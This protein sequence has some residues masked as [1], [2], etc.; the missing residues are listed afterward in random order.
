[1]KH[2]SIHIFIL[3]AAVLVAAPQ[4]SQ[5]IAALKT[6]LGQRVKAEIY[7][8]FLN[9][10]A[11]DATRPAPQT[12]E[13]LL[14]SRGAGAPRSKDESRAA[15][16]ATQV[17]VHARREVPVQSDES[18]ESDEVA[19]LTDPIMEVAELR[20]EPP[21]PAAP[22]V[23]FELH[24]R[25]VLRGTE[26]AMLIPPDA[27][28]TPAPRAAARRD[29]AEARA[30][31]RLRTRRA[32]ELKR[33]TASVTVQLDA[34]DAPGVQALYETEIRGQ[35]DALRLLGLDV[36]L[37]APRPAT[38]VLKLKRTAKPAPAPPAPAA[39]AACPTRPV[40]C[41]PTAP[42]AVFADE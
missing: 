29:A 24:D 3:L 27:D 38:K 12:P 2:R 37:D 30:A 36:Q 17:E 32:A 33:Q 9:L 5:D 42:D 34:D 41:G 20:D 13:S 6:A 18:D 22:A 19:M 15:R 8:A 40:A 31:T 39:R 25:K 35:L 7:K 21:A 16:A 1:M 28:I 11:S 4:A 14:A 10:Q 26:L 23:R